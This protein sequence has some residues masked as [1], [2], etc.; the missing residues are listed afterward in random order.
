M[1]I[2]AGPTATPK[3]QPPLPVEGPLVLE[4]PPVVRHARHLLPVEVRDRVAHAAARGVDAVALHAGEEVAL[5]LDH[6]V[7]DGA[8]S[9]AA[10]PAVKPCRS[11]RGDGPPPA[12]EAEG[13][14]AERGAEREAEAHCSEG[15]ERDS[16]DGVG[17]EVAEGV[18]LEVR[19][20]EEGGEGDEPRG[21]GGEEGGGEGEAPAEGAEGEELGPGEEGLPRGWLLF[22]S[23]LLRFCLVLLL[24]LLSEC[25]EGL[26]LLVGRGFCGDGGGAAGAGLGLDEVRRLRLCL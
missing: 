9:A 22:V 18:D 17:D 11:R 23:R 20:G 21:Q 8:C 14:G 12:E 13:E 6:G 2:R 1:R 19:G 25:L 26:L 7:V 3:A 16:H 4:P 15:E 24:L 10:D 5:A